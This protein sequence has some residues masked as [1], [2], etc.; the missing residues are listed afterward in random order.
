MLISN[1]DDHLR[2]H[3]FLRTTTGQWSLSPAFD[4][5]P[6]PGPGPTYLSTA[7]DGED[8]NASID[9][10][11]QVAPVF[12]LG[13]DR[14][15]AVLADVVGAHAQWPDVAAAHGLLPRAVAS[16]A[17]AFEHPQAERVRAVAR[18]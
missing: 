14:T 18:G 8:T 11:L 1:T 5:N 7:I 10:L 12:R 17:P 15:R 6:D 4:L 16:M 2:N 3:G 9:L 13:P